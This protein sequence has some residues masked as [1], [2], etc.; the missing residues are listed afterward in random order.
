LQMYYK[1]FNYGMVYCVL[2]DFDVTFVVVEYWL[3]NFFDIPNLDNR[4]WN[5][6]AYL[7]TFMKALYFDLVDD[8]ATIY[9]KIHHVKCQFWK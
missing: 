4:S 2:G 5:Q 7:A 1:M 9:S 6:M 3:L 8:N